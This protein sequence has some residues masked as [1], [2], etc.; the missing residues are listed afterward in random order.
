MVKTPT[1]HVFNMYKY[2]QDATLVESSIET[3][4]I[5]TQEEYQVPNLT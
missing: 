2:H 4:T 3:E 5:G 1:Y